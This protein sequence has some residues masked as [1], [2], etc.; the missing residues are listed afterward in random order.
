MEVIDSDVW[1]MLHQCF[2]HTSSA[3]AVVCSRCGALVANTLDFMPPSYTR[4]PP[5]THACWHVMVEKA[6]L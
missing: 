5:T 2:P 6:V 4:N 1:A 3:D